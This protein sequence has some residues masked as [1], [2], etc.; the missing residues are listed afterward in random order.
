[1]KELSQE[2][3]EHRN[4]IVNELLVQ[5]AEI[6]SAMIEINRI[7]SERLNVSIANYNAVLAEARSFRDDVA[8]GISQENTAGLAEVETKAL[9]DWLA[10]WEGADFDDVEV[11]LGFEGPT[12]EHGEEL[13][14]LGTEPEVEG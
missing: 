6:N 14:S 5:S 13:G 3:K 12:V 7:V 4:K 1:M 11:V 10:E 8:N 2:Q 9:Q